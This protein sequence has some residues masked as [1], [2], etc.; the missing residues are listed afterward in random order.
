MT[1]GEFLRKKTFV[2]GD[3]WSRQ[4]ESSVRERWEEK[5]CGRRATSVHRYIGRRRSDIGDIDKG[6]IFCYRRSQIL[7]RLVDDEGEV[8]EKIERRNF[9]MR[10]IEESGKWK[11]E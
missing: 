8:D 4:M 10:V 6:S 2:G 5:N 7:S 3:R 11:F 1:R 9:F